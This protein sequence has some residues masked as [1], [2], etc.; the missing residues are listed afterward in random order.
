MPE[1]TTGTSA[2]SEGAPQVPNAS[3][4]LLLVG[5]P[6]VGKSVIFGCLTGRYVTVSNY[7]GTTIEVTRGTASLD[8]RAVAVLDTPGTNQLTPRSEDERVTRDILLDSPEGKVVQVADAK[9]LRRALTLTLELAEMALPVTLALNMQ[10]EAR[11]R[12]VIV[13]R[14]RLSDLLGVAVVETTA[15]R[16]EG[17]ADLETA[18]PL[19]RRPSFRLTY[20]EPVEQEIASMLPHLAAEGDR[21]RF[22]ALQILSGSDSIWPYLKQRLSPSDLEAL[23]DHKSTSARNLGPGASREIRMARLTAAD[24][25]LREVYR[26]QAPLRTAFSSRI[27][28]WALHPVKGI[29]VMG[30]LLYLTFWFVGLFGAGTLVNL[31]ENGLFGQVV[32]PAAD[33]IVDAVLPFPHQHDTAVIQIAPAIPL[34]PN[35]SIRLG[36]HWSRTVPASSY[37]IP[38]GV[39]LSARQKVFRGAHDFL[40]G[41]Y[42]AISMGLSYGFAIVLPIVATFFL[43]FSLLED[44]GYLPRLAVMVNKL[45]RA[46]GLNGKAVLPMVL[47]LGCDTMATMTTRILETRKQR[48]IVTLLLALGVPCSAQLGVLLAMLSSVSFTGAIVWGVV[49][50]GVMVAVGYLAAKLLPGQRSDF[51]LE[52][53]PVRRPIVSNILIKT[54]ARIEWYLKEVLPLFL[55]GTALLFVLDRTHALIAV[56][57]AAEPLVVHWLGLPRETADA[58]VVGFLR[59]DYGAVFLLRAAT[60]AHPI[61]DG[62]QIVVSMTVITLFIPCIANVFIIVKE[63]GW[64]IAL[65]MAAFIFPFAFLIG[66]LVRLGASALHLKF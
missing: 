26:Q 3:L 52:L 53:P 33:H 10:D 46:M 5:N 20:P 11:A 49:V 14:Q 18:I 39:V 6:N 28:H 21:A 42:G 1:P 59:R 30:L 2:P 57:T 29:A 17:L 63:H 48:L 62:L 25:I 40:V 47:G 43:L 9:N 58:F 4:R 13:D 44:S 50:F 37:E 19:S 31:M 12:G 38:A 35:R 41:P 56:R 60:G 15:I 8:G 45:F 23:L 36:V 7:P 61:M 27:S 24:R 55:L 16:K 22:F 34:T 65:G 54:M 51:L 64:K 32:N 66:G